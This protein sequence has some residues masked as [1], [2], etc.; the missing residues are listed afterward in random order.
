MINKFA[1]LFS[2][3][4]LPS[5]SKFYRSVAFFFPPPII[6]FQFILF[7]IVTP[8]PLTKL[9]P[10]PPSI[11]SIKIFR[12]DFSSAKNEERR[13]IHLPDARRR[14]RRRRREAISNTCLENRQ[15]HWSQVFYI[16]YR[17]KSFF[18]F[19]THDDNGIS[20]VYDNETNL[21]ICIQPFV[22]NTYHTLLL[23]IP[24]I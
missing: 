9:F 14:N 10:S 19:I 13:V 17:L 12:V 8:D 7:R 3:P 16:S 18:F 22:Y 21:Y 2:P 5:P 20:I 6:S 23:S 24:F 1:P 4:P 15:Q 11:I